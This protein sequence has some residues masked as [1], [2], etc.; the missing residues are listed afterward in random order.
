MT[1]T[2]DYKKLNDLR[3]ELTKKIKDIKINK[4]DTKENLSLNLLSSKEIVPNTKVFVKSLNKNGIILSHISKSND[5][6]VL[7]GS[8]KM[9]V[10]ID[11]LAKCDFDNNVEKSTGNNS[12]NNNNSTLSIDRTNEIL[13]QI[14]DYINGEKKNLQ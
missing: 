9:S 10:S 7:V 8:L 6:Q 11:D 4:I 3:C 1:K 14:N 5:V 12:N 2:A 13:K